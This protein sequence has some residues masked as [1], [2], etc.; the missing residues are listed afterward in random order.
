[1]Y[2]HLGTVGVALAVFAWLAWVRWNE[3]IAPPTTPIRI[4]GV[5]A[6]LLLSVG[7]GLGGY[8]VYHGGAGVEPKLLAP[9]LRGG[10]SHN[11]KDAPGPTKDPI[12]PAKV[13]EH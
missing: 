1:M 5:I 8:I 9:E 11:E 12:T 7:G 10:H 13:H 2:W 3:K 4:V 6:A